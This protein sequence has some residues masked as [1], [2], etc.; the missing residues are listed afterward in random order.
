MI[1]KKDFEPIAQIDENIVLVPERKAFK[2][3]EISALPMIV[4]DFGALAA[5]AKDTEVI[6]IVKDTVKLALEDGCLAQIRMVLID[7]F[8][9]YLRQPKSTAKW[10]TVHRELYLSRNAPYDNLSEW[11]QFEDRSAGIIRENPSAADLTN[12]RVMFF[13]F[14]YRLE[15]LPSIP[16]RYA[17]VPVSSE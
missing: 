14:K 7:D 2:V 11:F 1:F 6:D 4:Y 5:G 8:I 16:A 12:T 15:P 17:A 13:G 10:T 9:L 3:R